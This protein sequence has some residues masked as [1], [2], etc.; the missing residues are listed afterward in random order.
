MA[1]ETVP[2]TGAS[3]AAVMLIVVVPLLTD[4][5]T[6]PGV[7]SLIVQVMVRLVLAP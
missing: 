5:A 4:P 2:L 6:T 7:P 3:L 1:L